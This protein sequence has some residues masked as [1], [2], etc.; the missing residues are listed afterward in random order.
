VCHRAYIET[1]ECYV[2]VGIKNTA[3]NFV[4]TR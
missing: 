4:N 3:I 2:T 1:V